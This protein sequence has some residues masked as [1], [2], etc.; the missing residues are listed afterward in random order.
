MKQRLLLALLMLLTSAGFM[1]ANVTFT[2]PKG[3][4]ATVTVN[5]STGNTIVLEVGS[6]SKQLTGTA[7]Y[8]IDKDDEAS[9]TV[10]IKNNGL[11]ELTITGKADNLQISDEDLVSLNSLKCWFNYVNRLNIN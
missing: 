4:T 7:S 8:T 2:V 11:L 5:V 3:E 6:V 1:K 10:K 9:Q